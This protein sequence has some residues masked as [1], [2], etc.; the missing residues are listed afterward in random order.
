MQTYQ[1]TRTRMVHTFSLILVT[2]LGC[3][4]A[5]R[6][7]ELHYF[8]A[9]DSLETLTSGTY[10]GLPNPNY[11]RLTFLFAHPSVEDPSSSHFHAIGAYSYTGP[12]EAPTVISEG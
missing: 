6:A 7:V 11:G 5:A 9:V 2:C 3:A 8:V 4:L 10:V 1:Q 12:V